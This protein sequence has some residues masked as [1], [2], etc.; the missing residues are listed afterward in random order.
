MSPNPKRFGCN[1]ILSGGR[2][3]IWA[4]EF[5]TIMENE[6]RARGFDLLFGVQGPAEN[7]FDRSTEQTVSRMISNSSA[8]L[9]GGVPL[10]GHWTAIPQA[11][12]QG[13]QCMSKR[14]AKVFTKRTKVYKED[15]GLQG[16]L[17]R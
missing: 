15:R 16:G 13:M 17:Q 3:F 4:L 10:A 1:F 6:M 14:F 11:R 2:P 8:A 9:S 12:I 5:S 7:P